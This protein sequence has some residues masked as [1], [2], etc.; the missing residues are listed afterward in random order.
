MIDQH[1]LFTPGD[2]FQWF[3]VQCYGSVPAFVEKFGFNGSQV[4]RTINNVSNPRLETLVVYALT[5]LNLHWMATGKGP[6]W[7]PDEVGRE[8][9]KKKGVVFAENEGSE[10]SATD[11]TALVRTIFEISERSVLEQLPYLYGADSTR[12]PSQ[13]KPTKHGKGKN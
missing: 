11:Y 6:W 1:D 12:Y 5:G 8:L 9:A 3:I 4:Y 2:R 10:S 7:S 13:A